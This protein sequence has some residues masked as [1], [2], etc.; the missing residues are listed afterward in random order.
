MYLKSYNNGMDESNIFQQISR[1]SMNSTKCISL[2][3]VLVNNDEIECNKFR[4]IIANNN[5]CV[6]FLFKKAFM[7]IKDKVISYSFKL[8]IHKAL[9]HTYSVRHL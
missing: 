9:F 7:E 2:S 6:S 4:D 3:Y 5:V 1:K 8:R